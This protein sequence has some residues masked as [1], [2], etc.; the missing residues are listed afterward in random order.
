[1]ANWWDNEDE[2]WITI[3]YNRNWF[4]FKSDLAY[5]DDWFW[6]RPVIDELDN[7]DDSVEFDEL[8]DVEQAGDKNVS[9]LQIKQE[10]TFDDLIFSFYDNLYESYHH[11]FF[12]LQG[13]H[14]RHY[15][16][17]LGDE[18]T[19]E[20]Y[21]DMD[22]MQSIDVDCQLRIFDQRFEENDDRRKDFVT[23]NRVMLLS[24]YRFCSSLR[25]LLPELVAS[26]WVVNNK[27]LLEIDIKASPLQI[28]H[29]LPPTL[30]YKE[31]LRDL[32]KLRQQKDASDDGIVFFKVRGMVL[33]GHK[34]LLSSS[35]PI[36]RD[37]I[38]KRSSEDE[39]VIL[40]R[41]IE[42]NAFIS[43]LTFIYSG[44]LQFR[45]E[46]A[47]DVLVAADY[48]DLKNILRYLLPIFDIDHILPHLNFFRR[49]ITNDLV[50]KYAIECVSS[51][52]EC[53]YDEPDLYDIDREV[54]EDLLKC[55]NNSMSESKLLETCVT[56]S[57]A[58][59]NRKR[60]PATRENQ[61]KV[62]GSCL[63]HIRYLRMTKEEFLLASVT[64]FIPLS[65]IS[66]VFLYLTQHDQ[67]PVTSLSTRERTSSQV[68]V[69]TFDSEIGENKE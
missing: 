48:F 36:F 24:D 66:E 14:F 13:V 15:T 6:T 58:E 3:S 16:K 17:L 26:G 64:G 11:K 4:Y 37:L 40:P 67:K 12:Y 1:M 8:Y 32:E 47:L 5:D 46:D 28:I 31:E 29:Y 35:S 21:A 68:S 18:V 60:L 61:K 45:E 30:S 54:L 59:C 62:L 20:I 27:M 52:M 53:I 43:L 65:V 56:W 44:K 50:Y 9:H 10:V 49:N 38:D 57:A 23:R 2:S 51:Y 42:V 33:V 63:D 55:D 41:I 7:Y 69:I 22:E 39:L 25:C 34:S 19:I